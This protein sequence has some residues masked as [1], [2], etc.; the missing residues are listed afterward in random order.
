V[1]R[2]APFFPVVLALVLL[3]GCSGQTDP[4]TNVG[5]NQAT[6]GNP[7]FRYAI[8]T[9]PDFS[10]PA[11]TA[12]HNQVIVTR[13]DQVGMLPALRAANPSATILVYK[14]LSMMTQWTGPT[15]SSG[16]TTVDA[17]SHEDWWLHSKATGARI[18]SG[19]WTYEAAG[20][21]GN[22]GYQQK[23]VQ[24]VLPQ[25]RNEGWDGVFMDDT[26]PTIKDHHDPNDVQEYANDTAY[27]NATQSMLAYVYPQIHNAG[28]QVYANIGEWGFG[29]GYQAYGQY[30]LANY[31]D[32]AMEEHWEPNNAWQLQNADFALA[33]GKT[34]LAH[35][36]SGNQVYGYATRQGAVS[37][38]GAP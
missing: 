16:V 13:A 28:F 19:T 32:G 22:A 9:N 8:D 3:A 23:W 30:W 27:A 33:H 6:L 18:Y 36:S 38:H 31:L 25:L 20:N 37:H 17:A 12:T 24:N 11:Y 26:N 15:A 35:Q 4:A 10:N 34:L 7:H 2:K 29:V 14:N 21:I 1:V 5:D